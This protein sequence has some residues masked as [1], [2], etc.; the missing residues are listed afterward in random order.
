[1]SRLNHG[2]RDASVE[3]HP[4]LQVETVSDSQVHNKGPPQTLSMTDTQTQPAVLLSARLPCLLPVHACC[5]GTCHGTSA[6][7]YILLYI[8]LADASVQSDLQ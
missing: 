8:P 3:S 6:L 7:L 2:L 4:C 1:M 5:Q